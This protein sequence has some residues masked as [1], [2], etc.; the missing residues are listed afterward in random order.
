ML[1][2]KYN[3]LQSWIVNLPKF[4]GALFWQHPSHI[5]SGRQSRQS[6]DLL[7]VVLECLWGSWQ[8]AGTAPLRAPEYRGCQGMWWSENHP[9]NGPLQIQKYCS[10]N[11]LTNFSFPLNLVA[12]VLFEFMHKIWNQNQRTKY[13][14]LQI[15][16]QNPE[17]ISKYLQ[18]IKTQLITTCIWDI[19]CG[20]TKLNLSYF[21]YC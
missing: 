4:G 18:I 7:L 15:N 3:I 11:L 12:A 1:F 8:P 10:H 9:E 5:V 19:S 16:Y 13:F 14:S 17:H 2:N 20:N 21:H 6:R